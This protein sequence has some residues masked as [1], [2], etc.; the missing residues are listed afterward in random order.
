M[1]ADYGSQRLSHYHQQQQQQQ[2]G[3]LVRIHHD[4]ERARRTL[5]HRWRRGTLCRTAYV[6]PPSSSLAPDKEKGKEKSSTSRHRRAHTTTTTT[7]TSTTSRGGSSSSGKNRVLRVTLDYPRLTR[8][9]T[10]LRTVLVQPPSRGVVE[11]LVSKRLYDVVTLAAGLCWAL[12]EG[13][14]GLGV[15]S[16]PREMEKKKSGPRDAAPWRRASGEAID[17]LFRV[18]SVLVVGCSRNDVGRFVTAALRG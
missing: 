6:L 16:T 15:R 4:Q 2:H 10:S 9:L 14:V 13:E 1:V 18:L 11:R 7:T 8:A 3:H 5:R 12:I 17:A